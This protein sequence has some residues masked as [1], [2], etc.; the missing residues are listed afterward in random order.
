[1]YRR[2]AA[3]ACC[4]SP[5]QPARR[6]CTRAHAPHR[7]RRRAPGCAFGPLRYLTPRC[8]PI[9]LTAAAPTDAS[10]APARW[11]KDARYACGLHSHPRPPVCRR[12]V[13]LSSQPQRSSRRVSLRAPRQASRRAAP[14][15][16]GPPPPR[17][18]SRAFGSTSALQPPSRSAQAC[19]YHNHRPRC[20]FRTCRR[21]RGRRG[22]VQSLSSKP[23][24]GCSVAPPPPRCSD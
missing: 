14:L 22:R 12:A 8:A 24:S 13:S 4:S 6:A 23:R 19:P 7:W 10:C 9:G 21:R 16:V 5:I 1:M 2:A 15:P 3:R 20:P 18:C 17:A 11:T